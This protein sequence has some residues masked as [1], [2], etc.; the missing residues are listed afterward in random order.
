MDKFLKL[1]LYIFFCIIFN[2]DCFSNSSF[3]VNDTNIINQKNTFKFQS[4][5]EFSGGYSTRRFVHWNLRT[6]NGIAFNNSIFT[7]VGLGLFNF[8]DQGT[9]K[10]SNYTYIPVFARVSVS[11]LNN[12]NYFIF[13]DFGAQFKGP[14]NPNNLEYSPVLKYEPTV[15]KPLFFRIGTGT[16]IKSNKNIFSIM[17]SYKYNK[18]RYFDTFDFYGPYIISDWYRSHTVELSVGIRLK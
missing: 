10:Y 16:K 17:V 7:G 1:Q 12:K 18:A 11:P 8:R 2:I 5:F 4:H 14:D 9:G 13:T 3:S 6:I 15:L